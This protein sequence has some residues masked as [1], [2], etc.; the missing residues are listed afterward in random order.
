K[1]T[2]HNVPRIRDVMALVDIVNHL[3]GEAK[4]IDDHTVTVENRLTKF[5]IPFEFAARTRVSFM[6][7]APLLKTFG[8]ASVPNPGG[9]RLGARP[10]D[11]LA[12]TA[13]RI[14]AKVEYNSNDGYY[15][16][17]L[18]KPHAA[19]IKFAKITHTGTELAIMNTVFVKGISTI[20]NAALEPEIDDMIEF[21]NKAGAEI[22]RQGNNIVVNGVSELL[23]VDMTVQFDR[24]EAVSYIILSALFNGGIV[25]KNVSAPD[26]AFFL[27]KF[28]K[29][30]FTYE[31]NKEA[32][33]FRI[34]VPKIIKPV[35]VETA[36][37]PGFITDWQPMWALLMAHAKGESKI[38]ETVFENRFGYVEELRK[39]GAKISYYDP[40]VFDPDVVYQFNI[41][42]V[43]TTLLQ[44]ICIHGPTKL[45]NGIVKM[46]DIRAGACLV[47]AALL[48]SGE[49]MVSGAEQIERG[50]EDLISKLRALGADIRSENL[51]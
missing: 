5:H 39:F 15:Y 2:L 43:N 48:A 25:V 29:A 14:G 50:Y 36:P 33:E 11:R 41:S 22:V 9:C 27:N 51:L 45:H 47:M 30:G 21:F 1:T 19:V 28:Q 20:K 42:H 17:T 37:H 16:I 24:N 3:G 35:N 31:N 10:V 18:S 46:T 7:L 4:F 6:L 49:S 34:K 8:K 44:A 32:N 38:H 26:I 23:G 12:Y 40:H 13:E